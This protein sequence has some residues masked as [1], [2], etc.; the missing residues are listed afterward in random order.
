MKKDG[1]E[2]S[3][4]ADGKP[5]QSAEGMRRSMRDGAGKS[6]KTGNTTTP[7]LKPE[8]LLRSR[9]SAVT[10]VNRE[11]SVQAR[12]TKGTKHKDQ[13]HLHLLRARVGSKVAQCPFA[14]CKHHDRRHLR[15]GKMVPNHRRRSSRVERHH[16][17]SSRGSLRLMAR[18]S[19]IRSRASRQEQASRHNRV[20]RAPTSNSRLNRSMCRPSSRLVL[21]LRMQPSSRPR[22]CS[23]RSLSL[24][25]SHKRR[26]ACLA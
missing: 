9:K 2:K 10:E 23:L 17:D 6:R 3:K 26:R 11:M 5:S 25:R 7:Y 22:Q 12:T 4:T 16:M 19:N 13:R 21:Q 18:V 15:Q 1:E 20:R 8:R 14:T 24:P